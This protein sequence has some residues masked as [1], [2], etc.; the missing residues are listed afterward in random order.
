MYLKGILVVGNEYIIY[1]W[2]KFLQFMANKQNNPD[3][4][5]DDYANIKNVQVQLFENL[6]I[7]LQNQ[8]DKGDNQDL[9]VNNQAMIIKNQ[10][11]IVNNQVRIIQNQQKIVDNQGFLS[12]IL[13][14]QLLSLQL[15]ESLTSDKKL[16]EDTKEKI[17]ALKKALE[18]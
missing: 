4:I 8:K 6:N 5:A 16:S 10:D 2:A 1:I 3:N 15:L 13:E 14:S 11:I 7:L 12:M 17:N 9:V 18:K